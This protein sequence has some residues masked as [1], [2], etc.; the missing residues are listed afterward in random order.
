MLV[1]NLDSPAIAWRIRTIYLREPFGDP[2]RLEPKDR[3]QV[4]WPVLREVADVEGANLLFEASRVYPGS[5]ASIL[6]LLTQIGYPGKNFQP[7]RFSDAVAVAGL[8]AARDFSARA[9]VLVLGAFD[10]DAS[11]H[12]PASVRRYLEE[13]HVPLYV[14]SL[15]GPGPGVPA[16]AWGAFTDVSTAAALAGAAD[17]VR[18]DLA[19]QSIA[20][21]EGQ[22]LPQEITLVDNGDGLS[23]AR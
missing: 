1:R 19:S 5:R 23:L 7:T 18:Q 22:Y 8:Q 21:V 9:V 14:W 6:T 16:S 13:L 3:L 15:A 4:Q 12:D 11:R 17:R 10:K 2:T 20:W